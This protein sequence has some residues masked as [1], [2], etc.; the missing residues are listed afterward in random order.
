MET[1]E[2]LDRKKTKAA[3]IRLHQNAQR[4]LLPVEV[5]NPHAASL[6][7]S[8]KRTRSRRDHMK[9]LSLIR[10]IAFLHQH[11]RPT[12]RT[13]DG[14]LY[15]EANADDV[16]TAEHLLRK[17]L[18]NAVEELPPQTRSLLERIQ[19]YCEQQAE[20]G[21]QASEVVF[22]RRQLREATGLGDTQ[23]KVHLSRL[24]GLELLSAR[25]QSYH[26]GLRYRL[27]LEN[28]RAPSVGALVG[29]VGAKSQSVGHRSGIGRPPTPTDQAPEK[30][31]EKTTLGP[32]VGLFGS[33]SL[34]SQKLKGS[35]LLISAQPK[36][37]N[38]VAK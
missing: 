14:T 13:E 23:L 25:R 9:L 19:A 30:K 16:K 5:V 38:G 2:R 26:E 37:M 8:G 18:D 35:D 32:S 20:E 24:V 29:K 33:T 21:E 4:L 3:L 6:A 17:L 31:Q 27:H 34:G 12:K 36:R 15:I 11:Q 28:E 1:L 22:S 10:S 7:F